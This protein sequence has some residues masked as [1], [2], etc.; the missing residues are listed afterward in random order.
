MRIRLATTLLLL[1]QASQAQSPDDFI[2]TYSLE[3]AQ[4]QS[5]FQV[6]ATRG[7]A[8]AARKWGISE[9][10]ASCTACHTENPRNPGRHSVTN[11]VIQPLSPAVNPERFSDPAKVEKWF[12]RNCKEVVGRPCTAAEKAD[13]IQFVVGAK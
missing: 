13:F 5:R 9:N 4:M 8:F 7:A 2:V 6:S 11:K 12:R 3:A 1:S 10:L